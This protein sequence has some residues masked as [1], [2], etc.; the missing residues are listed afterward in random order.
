MK[1]ESRFVEL[2]F[3]MREA[4]EGVTLISHAPPWGS[5]SEDMMGF[6]EKFERGSFVNLDD[7][8]VATFNHNS[9][10]I[11]GRTAAGTLDLEEDDEGLRYEVDLPD[12]TVGQ[13]LAKSIRR[14]DIRGSSFEFSVEPGGEKWETAKDGLPIRTVTKARLYQVGPVTNPA[15]QDTSVALRSLDEWRKA[16]D[17]GPVGDIGAAK[18]RLRLAEIGG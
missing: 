12:T 5:L 2:R 18:R 1:T 16:S 15:Y 8:I 6:Q 3:S 10:A 4:V 14:G 17:P 9:S 7:D 11:L 13:D